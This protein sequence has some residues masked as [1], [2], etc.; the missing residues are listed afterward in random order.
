MKVRQLQE[1]LAKIDPEIAVVCYNKDKRLLTTGRGTI[2]FD[3]L[4]VTITEAQRCRLDD[5]TPYLVYEK[6]PAS[7]PTAIV[8]VTSDF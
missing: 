6:G 2:L 8:E 5:G 7:A 1:T 4:A 3:I